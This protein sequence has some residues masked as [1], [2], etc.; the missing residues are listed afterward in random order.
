MDDQDQ[1][2]TI[3][4]G[5]EILFTV[6]NQTIGVFPTMVVGVEKFF[7]AFGVYNVSGM[8]LVSAPNSTQHVIMTVI[9]AVDL[10][11]PSV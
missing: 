10:S 2:V 6:V 3:N 9:D 7:S 11:V 4:S 1:V 8:Q 5:S